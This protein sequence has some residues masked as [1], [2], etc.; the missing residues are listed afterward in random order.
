MSLLLDV[1]YLL[2]AA[3]LSPW[4]LYA[5]AFKHNYRQG[6]LARFG[7]PPPPA[8]NQSIWLHGASAGEVLVMKPLLERLETRLPEATF[9]ISTVTST[10][11]LT[12]EKAYPRHQVIY[13][14]LDLSPIVRM[15]LRRL[16]PRVV[17]IF[18]SEFWPNFILC[19]ERA[20]IP[21]VLLNGKLSPRSYAAYKRTLL[22]PWLLKKLSLLAVQ[23]EEYAERFRQL[24][25]PQKKITVTGNM[26]YD[27]A[28]SDPGD[29]SV[30]SA[31]RQEFGYREDS[32]ILVGG[33]THS[34]EHEA[35]IY[36][37]SRLRKEGHRLQLILVP[38]YPAEAAHIKHIV[39]DSA[40]LAVRRTS[41]YETAHMSS[42][43]NCDTVLIVDTMGELRKFYAMADIAYVG[44]SLFFRKSNKGGHNL[45]EPAMLGLAVLFGPYNFSFRDTV[46]TLMNETAGIMVQNQEDL[47]EQLFDLLSRPQRIA[48][49]GHKARTV[50]LKERGATAKNIELLSRLTAQPARALC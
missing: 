13:F 11:K 36:A 23:N 19:A 38:R 30:R 5:L 20:S 22:V 24:G 18:E 9:V 46:A 10:G 32:I 44:G 1:M 43:D 50:M 25:V 4:L 28:S 6:L 40:L 49:L 17:I 47:Y 39:E 33:S 15:F 8:L 29:R 26:K 16:K 35:L 21:M 42:L 45:M 14:P 34:G 37:F 31:L 3:V 2:I 12:A 7:L 48:E 41:L 27:L